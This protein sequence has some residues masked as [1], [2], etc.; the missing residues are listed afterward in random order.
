[1]A[2]LELYGQ[3]LGTLGTG[4]MVDGVR[5]SQ[6]GFVPLGQLCYLAGVGMTL[7]G[8]WLIREYRENTH[9]K[10][11]G[12]PVSKNDGAQLMAYFRTHPSAYRVFENWRRKKG[13]ALVTY[14]ELEALRPDLERAAARDEAFAL[15]NEEHCRAA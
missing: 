7:R 2:E 14:G 11:Q 3:L 4:L 8:W 13:T 15:L 12:Y 9:S 5:L 10:V 6:A 1:L